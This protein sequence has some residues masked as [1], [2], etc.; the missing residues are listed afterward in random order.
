MDEPFWI[1]WIALIVII[2]GAL[3]YKLQKLYLFMYGLSGVTLITAVI[4]ALTQSE[5]GR[6]VILLT[7]VGAGLI[8]MIEGYITSH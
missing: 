8:M 2:H 5:M 4:Y 1:F 3:S 6:E 7:L